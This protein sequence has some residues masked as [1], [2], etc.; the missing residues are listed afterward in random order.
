MITFK[1]Y[2]T[3]AGNL[4]AECSG[5]AGYAEKGQDIV[6][7]AASMIMTGLIAALHK[8]G[9]RAY[10]VNRDGYVRVGVQYSDRTADF[11]TYAVSSFE[12][13][14]SKYPEH[15]RIENKKFKD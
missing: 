4:T 8:T 9:C 1:H 7:S 2:I 5:H 12:W 3:S 14:A 15:V 10:T 6:C 13:L 11:F